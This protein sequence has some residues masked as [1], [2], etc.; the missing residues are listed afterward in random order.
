MMF[1]LVIS[2]VCLHD[3]L[4]VLFV[5]QYYHRMTFPNAKGSRRNFFLCLYMVDIVQCVPRAGRYS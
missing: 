5:F 2:C 4:V 1:L 3:M